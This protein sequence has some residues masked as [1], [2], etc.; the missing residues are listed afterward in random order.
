VNEK[1]E[2]GQ[3][4]DILRLLRHGTSKNPADEEPGAEVKQQIQDV[5]A[6]R[7]VPIEGSIEE[8]RAVQDRPDHVIE[9]ADK[10]VPPVEMGVDENREEVIVLKVALKGTNV[11]GHSDHDEKNLQEPG[12]H[13]EAIHGVVILHRAL[14]V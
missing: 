11:G 7:T 8:K 10:R 5:V 3:E 12:A 4:W 13:H 1:H 6:G 2:R 14:M 9:M